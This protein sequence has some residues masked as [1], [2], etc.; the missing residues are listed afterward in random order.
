MSEKS[1]RIDLGLAVLSTVAKPGEP[2]TWEDVAAW[3]DCHPEAIRQ[4]ERRALQKVRRR[5]QRLGVDR[6]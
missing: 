6:P 1:E 2:L 5:L 3:C 4:I